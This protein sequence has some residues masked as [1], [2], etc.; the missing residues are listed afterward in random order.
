[1]RRWLAL[2]LLVAFSWLGGLGQDAQAG[3]TIDVLFQ[4]ATVPSG[5][6]I[7]PGD[8]A[9][10]GCTFS[11]YHGTVV[12]GVRCMD[13]VLKSTDD[14]V[15]FSMSVAYDSD[16]GLALVSMH[17]WRG[18]GVS[19]GKGQPPP[20][21]QS[22]APEGGLSDN[23]GML[24]SFDCSIPEPTNPPVL[25]PGTYKIGTITWDASCLAWHEWGTAAVVAAY[26]DD[27]VDA[28]TA[29]R[30][31]NIV[32]ISDEVV[33]GS[34]ILSIPGWWP[35][36]SDGI[37]EDSEACDDGNTT[38]GD[39]CAVCCQIESGWTCEGQPSVCTEDP[40]P[41]PSVGATGAA[42]LGVAV[43]GIGLVGLTLAARR[44]GN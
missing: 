12:T 11:G 2:V 23:G 36:C 7:A 8:T 6:T 26:I 5:I 19:F 35:P 3:V 15:G 14:L 13:V 1:M 16:E 34:H 38:P 44:R 27:S 39:G 37:I 30:N 4:D 18:V 42:V 25:A 31:G 22:C 29:A 10:P 20:L 28:F 40:T 9:A 24:Q 32:D 17:E 41:V 43:F 33:A 21:V